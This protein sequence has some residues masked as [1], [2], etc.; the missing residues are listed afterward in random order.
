MKTKLIIILLIIGLAT[1]CGTKKNN[2]SAAYE[3][4]TETQTE[5][6]TE[7]NDTTTAKIATEQAMS[8]AKI[9]ETKDRYQMENGQFVEK[10]F[11][12]I[13]GSFKNETNAKNLRNTLSK[14]GM[15]AF[16]AVNKDGMFRVFA[17]SSDDEKTVR[18]ELVKVR[19]TYP[20]AWILKLSK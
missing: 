17:V 2:L 15:N 3:V 12:I 16:V 19:Q 1:A 14:N 9:T 4:A 13:V 7:T 8:D 11:H 18:I 6:Q 20:D 5:V 10:P